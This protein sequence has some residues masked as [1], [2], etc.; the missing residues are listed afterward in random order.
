MKALATKRRRT[1]LAKALICLAALF[2][3][4]ATV[5]IAHE[6][7]V[8]PAA[9]YGNDNIISAVIWQYD[10]P[11]LCGPCGPAS[12]LDQSG[13]GCINMLPYPEFRAFC[14]KHKA[15]TPVVWAVAARFTLR[16]EQPRLSS[17]ELHLLVAGH[18]TQ[19]TKLAEIFQHIRDFVS[20]NCPTN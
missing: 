20:R 4:A 3:I 19:E 13:I 7:L 1:L 6:Q 14:L 2:A 8:I 16:G 18:F 17:T 10:F 15:A 5:V 9:L 11:V 12:H